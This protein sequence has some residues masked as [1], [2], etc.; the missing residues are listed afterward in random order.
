MIGEM[1]LLAS[2]TCPQ[3]SGIITNVKKYQERTGFTNSETQ[4]VIDVL[5]KSTPECFDEGPEQYH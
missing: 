1:I 3:V 4:E 5:K 2:L